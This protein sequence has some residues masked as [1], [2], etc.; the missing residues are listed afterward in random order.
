MMIEDDSTRHLNNKINEQNPAEWLAKFKNN[1]NDEG[2]PPR[3]A[4]GG[5]A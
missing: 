2:A 3:G 5:R 4:A 1:A